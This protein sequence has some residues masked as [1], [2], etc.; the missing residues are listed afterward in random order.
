LTAP[1]IIIVVVIIVPVTHPLVVLTVSHVSPLIPALKLCSC[2]RILIASGRTQAHR[3]TMPFKFMSSILPTIAFSKDAF[4]NQR[5]LPR[6]GPN[7]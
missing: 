1:V 7:H 4:P 6:A 5:R 3:V 2:R